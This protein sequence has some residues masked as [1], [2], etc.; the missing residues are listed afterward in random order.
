MFDQHRAGEALIISA[1][2]AALLF[3]VA[4]AP[5]PEDPAGGGDD[6]TTTQHET[7]PPE[8]DGTVPEGAEAGGADTT[9]G[10]DPQAEDLELDVLPVPYPQNLAIAY[11]AEGL[12]VSWTP[13]LGEDGRLWTEAEV[14]GYGWTLTSAEDYVDV[15]SGH[16]EDDPLQL[17]HLPA[18]DYVFTLYADDAR[19]G[20]PGG[21]WT[22][23]RFTAEETEDGMIYYVTDA[24]VDERVM[25]Y[26]TLSDD[27]GSAPDSSFIAL[28]TTTEITGEDSVEGLTV[29][30]GGDDQYRERTVGHRWEVVDEYG[31][32]GSGEAFA[33]GATGE[34]QFTVEGLSAGEYTLVVTAEDGRL[35]GVGAN[36]TLVELTVT[37]EGDELT[38]SLGTPQPVAQ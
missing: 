33:S 3:G 25:F 31:P 23:L 27:D 7:T 36:P 4:C 17:D 6:T 35:H 37:G 11:D 2:S 30:V 18:G 38:H 32:G 9:G 28:P 24:P 26:D 1:A 10:G 12:T 34:D 15:D 29:T 19:D 22:E 20:G 13:P 5:P 21:D 14:P 16:I 8:A